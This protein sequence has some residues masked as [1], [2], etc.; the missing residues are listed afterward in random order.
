MYVFQL[1][2]YYSGSRII[3]LVAAFELLAICYIYGVSRFLDNIRMMLGDVWMVHTL[4]YMKVCW[5]VLSPIFCVAIFVMSAINY[6]ELR[7]QRPGK[8]EYK[9]PNWAVSIGWTLAA[10]SAV[11]IP[12]VALYK[13]IKNGASFE[14]FTLLCKPYGL[15]PHQLR[16]QDHGERTLK[17]LELK[18]HGGRTVE[19]GPDPGASP[20][21]SP[22]IHTAATYDEKDGQVNKAFTP[23][24][25][26]V[27]LSFRL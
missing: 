25:P 15:M 16:P 19:H 23:H 24:G 9:Y 13:W 21:T 22:S 27:M 3:L 8:R 18:R 26:A 7:Y 11:W 14:A 1:F 2:D 20:S 4:P 6:S 17:D 12:I 10:S 5:T